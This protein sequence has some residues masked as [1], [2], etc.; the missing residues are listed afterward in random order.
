MKH[1]IYDTTDVLYIFLLQVDTRDP[2]FYAKL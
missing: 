1:N 2:G